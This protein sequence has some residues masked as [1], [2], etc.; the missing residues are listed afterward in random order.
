M[1]N[2]HV[3]VPTD[4]SRAAGL[5]SP[6]SSVLS[7]FRPS[8]VLSPVPRLQSS[9]ISVAALVPYPENTTPSQRFR[10][11]QWI[12]RLRQQGIRVDL[13]PFADDRTVRLLHRPGAAVAKAA[14]LGNGFIRRLPDIVRVKR[15]DAVLIHRAL[16]LAGPAILER[17]ITWLGT[18][19]I[20]D[21]DDAIWA[22]HTT[23]ANRRSGW[24]KFPGKTAAICRLS[25]H[26]VVGNSYL[27]EYASRYSKHVTI[28]PTS[29]DT[30]CY[31]PLPKPAPN[32]HVV[33]GWTG[34]S[35][36][37]THLEA[38]APQLRDLMDRSGVKFRVISDR[39]P[40]LPGI[41]FVWR[42]WTAD[43]EVE[44]L[45][46]LDIGIMPMPDDQWSRGK[47]ALKALQY[48]A[49][50]IPAVCSSVGTNREVIHHGEN[51]LLATTPEEWRA[52][53]HALVDDPSLRVRLGTAGRKTIEADYSM[54]R[55][56]DL[57]AQVVEETLGVAKRNSKG[58]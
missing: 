29:V 20:F 33:V 24:L 42:P 15:Y 30:N 58:V 17:I 13:L 7:T 41:D 40:L 38:F 47:C 34:S 52:S 1:R 48:M 26:V 10:I 18:P 45:R 36:S 19:V 4:N 22:L 55:C 28:I 44:E 53:L 32:G 31:Q 37:Q 56:A 23:E 57:F 16:C 49:M 21:F 5:H 11:E 43:N 35:T 50:G 3:K 46:A 2:T 12:P 54:I 25:D 9:P 39:E 27:A 8:S 6:Q 51:G 14:A